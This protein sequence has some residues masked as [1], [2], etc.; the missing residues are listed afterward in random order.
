MR[1]ESSSIVYLSQV[2]VCTMECTEQAWP[3][4]AIVQTSRIR[5]DVAKMKNRQDMCF[6]EDHGPVT[7]VD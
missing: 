6:E 3:V 1:K 2:P 5:N 4:F 7:N